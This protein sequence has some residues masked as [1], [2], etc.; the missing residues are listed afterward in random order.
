M[1]NLPP[2]LEL[3]TTFDVVRRF[4]GQSSVTAVPFTRVSVAA[5]LGGMCTVANTTIQLFASGFRLRGITIWPAAG[6]SVL[7]DV[8]AAA[9]GAEQALNRESVKNS[10]VPT[11][12]TVDRAMRWTPK[13]GTYLDMWQSTTENPTDQLFAFSGAAGAVLDVHMTCTLVGAT[14]ASHNV[15][16]TSTVAQGTVVVMRLD[17]SNNFQVIGYNNASW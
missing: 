17:T 9:A 15:T 6:S 3:V 7:L 1:P 14:S 12:V 4:Q 8:N 11:G 13:P 5:A 10:V 2:R 16:T